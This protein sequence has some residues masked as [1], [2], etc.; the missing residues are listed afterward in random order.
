MTRSWSVHLKVCALMGCL[1]TQPL[2]TLAQDGV[3]AQ[4]APEGAISSGGSRPDGYQVQNGDTLWSISGQFWGD[5]FFWP[6]LW[7]YNP[8][9][10]NAHLIYPGNTLRF[11]PGSYV[12]IPGMELEGNGPGRSASGEELVEVAGN[13]SSSG[14]GSDGI[15]RPVVPFLERT[16]KFSIRSTGFLREQGFA[17]LGSVMKAPVAKELLAEGDLVYLQFNRMADVSCGD[18]YTIYEPVRNSVPHPIFRGRVLGTIYRTL[19]E[20]E[21]VDVND[22]AATARIRRSYA[23]IRRGNL[24]TARE[25]VDF[26]VTIQR[27]SKELKGYIVESLNQE[28]S[29][30]GINDIIYIDRGEQDNVSPG[31][32]FYVVRQGDGVEGLWRVGTKDV[33][34][35]YQVVGRVVVV[36][37]GEFVSK[38][39]ITEASGV[40]EIGDYITT[41]LD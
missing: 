20:V 8:Y 4:A 25:P 35:P 38:A 9:I 16:G 15:C 19:G 6:T 34:L 41:Q 27:S 37:P 21:V 23:E 30:L 14:N 36:E 26:T 29:T 31:E 40:I 33:T 17:P 10:G 11:S 24:V 5:S 39:V 32:V 3:G 22:F 18:V 1:L 12:R 2:T 7:S 13:T 28:T